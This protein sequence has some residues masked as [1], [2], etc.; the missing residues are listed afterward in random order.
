MKWMKRLVLV[1]LGLVLGLVAAEGVWRVAALFRGGS[2]AGAVGDAEIRLLCEGD[3]N[4][5]GVRV[6]V[7]DSYPERVAKLI[8]EGLAPDDARRVAVVNHGVPG[9]NTAQILG[10]IDDDVAESRPQLVL[11][12]AGLNNSWNAAAPTFFDR[13]RVVRLAKILLH[14]AAVGARGDANSIPERAAVA[15]LSGE[16]S[17][18]ELEAQTRADLVAIAARVRAAGASPVL[19]TYP[20]HHPHMGPFNRAA[21]AA[22]A[23][24]GALLVDLDKTFDAHIARYG[25]EALFFEDTHA[26]E[27]GYRLMARDIVTTL[28]DGGALPGVRRPTG[29]EEI[30]ARAHLAIEVEHDAAGR[31]VALALT[32]EPN[33]G[34]QVFVSPV[35]E[36]E[37]DLGTRKVPIGV[38]PWLEESRKTAAF[39]GALDAAGRAR[40]E[41]PAAVSDLPA[42]S[43]LY[44]AFVT[45]DPRATNELAYRSISPRVEIRRS[46]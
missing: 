29:E 9:R 34:F 15:R 28:V 36:P 43:V 38:H 41:L 3:S 12:L 35:T 42:E 39:R 14:D 10:A 31:A 22:A 7:S 37:L 21:R 2:R 23:E 24:S 33:A 13:L 25:F 4:T 26:A 17:E 6:A 18:A 30:V 1:V 19:L 8:R 44:A 40:V 46:R 11:V 20:G 5:F 16:R 27:P 32:G 45:L